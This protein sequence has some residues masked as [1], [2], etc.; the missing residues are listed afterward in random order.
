[1]RQTREKSFNNPD[2]M[3]RSTRSG[4]PV[5]LFRCVRVLETK[6]WKRSFFELETSPLGLLLSDAP[7][8]RAIPFPGV[9][10][11]TVRPSVAA[12]EQDDAIAPLVIGEMA[13]GSRS[14]AGG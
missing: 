2:D 7:P 1:M 11:I 14:R 8:D 4:R 10:E 13:H 9:V 3:K 12:A 6:K 5:M